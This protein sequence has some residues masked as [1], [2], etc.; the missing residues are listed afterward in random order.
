MNVGVT[1]GVIVIVRVAVVAHKPAVGVKVY[2]VVALLFIAGLHVPV[3]PFVDVVGS[4]G[5]VAP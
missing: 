4:A 1:P 5:I 3:M 2:T